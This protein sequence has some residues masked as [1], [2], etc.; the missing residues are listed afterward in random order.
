MNGFEKP[1]WSVT[2][3]QSYTV[4]NVQ[5][6]TSMRSNSVMQPGYKNTHLPLYH[7]NVVRPATQIQCCR[8]T[9][10]WN[11]SVRFCGLLRYSM[12]KKFRL[13]LHERFWLQ[14]PRELGGS[15]DDHTFHES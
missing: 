15:R 7:F 3:Q 10:E 14:F 12:K 1:E 9:T 4:S 6:G 5:Q 8:V 2:D 13:S 11:I